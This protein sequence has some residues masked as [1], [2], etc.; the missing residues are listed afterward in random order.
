MF[1]LEL[2]AVIRQDL[3][4]NEDIGNRML[5]C[6][7]LNIIIEPETNDLLKVARDTL[8]LTEFEKKDSFFNQVSKHSNLVCYI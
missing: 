2:E 8:D 4:P 3:Q 6:T 5:A 7:C 1:L